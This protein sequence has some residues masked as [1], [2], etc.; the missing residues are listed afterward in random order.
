[1][2]FFK[3]IMFCQQYLEIILISLKVARGH[4][5]GSLSGIVSHEKAKTESQNHGMF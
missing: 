3:V 2:Y 4:Q 5:G 1:M